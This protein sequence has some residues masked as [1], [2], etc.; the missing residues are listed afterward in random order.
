VVVIA[1]DP[2]LDTESEGRITASSL[3]ICTSES[4]AGA[5]SV[6]AVAA[7]TGSVASDTQSVASDTQSVVV[8]DAACI[9]ACKEEYA[10]DMTTLLESESVTVD[11]T[12]LV[13]LENED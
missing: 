11:D 9:S 3:S 6:V 13:I 8:A 12:E 7:S 1:L 5:Q 2:Q 4:A 10:T